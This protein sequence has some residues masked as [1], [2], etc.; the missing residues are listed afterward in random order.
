MA[1]STNTLNNASGKV[2]E[3]NI[4]QENPQGLPDK[5]GMVTAQAIP[6]Y[7]YVQFINGRDPGV[8]LEFHYASKTH[9]LKHYT[10]FHG[11]NYDLPVEIID[12]LENCAERNYGYRTGESGHPEAYVKS[13]KYIFQCKPAK[14]AA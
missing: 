12:H 7:R 14:R 13:L 6:E 4:L 10:L 2:I 3:D 1:R 8:A 5:L 11:Y 9:P